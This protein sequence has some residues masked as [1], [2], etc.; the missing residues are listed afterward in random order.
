MSH[1]RFAVSCAL[2]L[3]AGVSGCEKRGEHRAPAREKVAKRAPVK[4]QVV[5]GATTVSKAEWIDSM[6]AILPASFCKPGMYFREC[7]DVTENECLETSMRAT[8]TCL[9]KHRDEIPD[10]LVQPQEGTE[11]GTKVGSCAGS[12]YDVSLI[13]RRSSNEKC[14]DPS[15]WASA[16]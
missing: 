8:K 1:G 4:R 13:Q 7:Y 10:P 15:N 6:T 11:W 12:V 5:A 3:I 9:M 16:Q 14:E 2:V